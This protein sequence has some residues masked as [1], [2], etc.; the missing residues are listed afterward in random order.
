MASAVE[1]IKNTISAAMENHIGAGDANIVSLIEDSVFDYCEKEYVGI[2]GAKILI[3]D[4]KNEMLGFGILQPLFEQKDITEIMVNAGRVFY[5][6]GGR[7][8]NS[9]I[10]MA[11]GGHLMKIIRTICRKSGRTVNMAS[12]I[13]DACLDDG[14]RINIVLDPVSVDGHS[15]TIRKFPDEPMSGYDLMHSG[16]ITEEAMCFLE[17]VY[18][19]RYNIFIC[20]GAG[21][22]KTTLLNVLA[23]CSGKYERL[24]TIEDSAEL[25]IDSVENLVRLET[26]TGNSGSREITIRD[27]IK[28]SLRMRPDRIIVGEVRGA[29]ALDMLQAMNTGHEGSV[30]TGHANSC[31]ELISRIETM[32]LMGADM[33]LQAVRKQIISAIDIIVC[34]GRNSKKRYVSRIAELLPGSVSEPEFNL[35]Y[36]YNHTSGILC[37]RGHLVNSEKMK[38]ADHA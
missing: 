13:T 15:I 31:E 30:S 35:L 8:F 9:G 16:F 32:V 27:L 22:G 20:G 24:I 7:I 1:S 19:A 28:T 37:K 5:E 2:S 36:D 4:I 23:N 29:E 12:P 18:R 38:R 26:R 25:C 34:L 10:N 11:D 6:K 3:N 14:T 21:T 17:D 33:P